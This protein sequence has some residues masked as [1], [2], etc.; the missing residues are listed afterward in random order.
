MIRLSLP[1]TLLLA[2]II[3][4]LIHNMA[5][6]IS[7]L[8][9]SFL[10]NIFACK[11]VTKFLR[12]TIP[13]AVFV[14]ALALMQWL[15]HGFHPA[16][17]AK[18]LA[19]FWLIASAFRLTPWNLYTDTMGPGSR[20]S[21]PILYLLFVRHFSWILAGESRRLLIARSRVVCRSFGRWSFRSLAAALV[22]LFLRTIT[23]AERFYAAQ[24]LKGF[25]K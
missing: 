3:V 6:I 4:A 24:I 9:A 23:R 13:V 15:Y 7:A 10:L 25:S 11:S 20:L 14:A 8:A 18:T 1:I 17:A 5:L 16:T 21:A 22:S 12:A 2:A 19:V